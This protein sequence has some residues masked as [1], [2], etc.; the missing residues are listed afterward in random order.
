[1]PL[2]PH[3]VLLD[4][5]RA[6]PEEGEPTEAGASLLFTAPVR[7][8]RADNL[9][10]IPALLDSL[11]AEVAAGHHVAGYLAY[12]AGAAFWADRLTVA[13]PREPLAWFGVYGPPTVLDAPG[14]DALLADAHGYALTVPR[15]DLDR[16]AYVQQVER[17][18]H[19]IHEGDVYQINFTAPFRYRFAGDPVGLY[20]A[21]RRQQRVSYA[22]LLHIEAADGQPL[23][24]LSLSPELFFRRDGRRLTARPMKGTIRRGTDAGEDAALAMHLSADPKNRAENLMIV[25]LLRNDLSVV[26]EP[27]SVVVPHLFTTEPYETLTQMTSTVQA[28]LRDGVTYADLFEALFPCGSVT[29]AP[30]LRAMQ[31][32]ADLEA[33]PRGVYCGAVGY[34]APPTDSRDA[35]AVFNVP[36][37]TLVLAEDRDGMGTGTMG[38]GSGIVWDSDPEAEY[39][40]CQLKA[41]FLKRAWAWPERPHGPIQDRYVEAAGSFGLLETM[42]AERGR[43]EYRALH[44]VRLA[45]AA[46]FFGVKLDLAEVNA[47]LDETLAQLGMAPHRLRLTVAADGTPGLAVAPVVSGDMALRTAALF[48]VAMDSA[49]PFCWWK[50]THRTHYDDAL[51]W[52]KTHAV[53]EPLLLNERGEVTE[54][55]RTSVW[56]EREGQLLTPPLSS[57]GL[58][59]VHRQHLLTTVPGAVEAVLVS[60]DLHTADRVLLGNAVRGLQEVE[61]VEVAA[62]SLS[63]R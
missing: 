24:V 41:R 51:A 12:E 17:V 21:L 20:R 45:E 18:R 19:H 5:P 43:I 26:A 59:G 61:V 49:N 13:A 34:I 31:L 35:Q 9:D 55:A 22:A 15:F 52:A 53:D 48:P 54:G 7:I 10:A 32:I 38:S 3:A 28:T 44:R 33:V 16:D 60:E 57:G 62:A 39:D 46:S 47:L 37:R 42:R 29:G 63:G 50:T 40:E 23:D 4:A 8:L 1:M 56:I 14:V 2:P 6:A 30:K 58:A 27:G 36:I 11:D 25:D